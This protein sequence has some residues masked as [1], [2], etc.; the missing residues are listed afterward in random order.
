MTSSVLRFLNYT[1]TL[2]I[3]WDSSRRVFGPS[4]THDSHKR[5]PCPYRFRTRNPSTRRGADPRLRPVAPRTAYRRACLWLGSCSSYVIII[6]YFQCKETS[7]SG[8]T[9][10]I[11]VTVFPTLFCIALKPANLLTPQYICVAIVNLFVKM[12]SPVACTQSGLFLTWICLTA[13]G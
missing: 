2:H 6:H 13:G 12:A 11:T 3:R 4:Q 5:K 10:Y 8:P 9:S 1:Q 7:P